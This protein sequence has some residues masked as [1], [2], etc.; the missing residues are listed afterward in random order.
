MDADEFGRLLDGSGP[1]RELTADERRA[2][3]MMIVES[4]PP[5]KHRRLARPIAIG[6]IAVTLLG[7]GGVAAAAVTG[8]W[9]QWAQD[10]PLAVLHYKL[11]SGIACEM[12]IGNI[13]E[14]PTEAA[15]VIRESLAG[16]E[17]NDD[18]VVENAIA[19][20]DVLRNDDAY[21]SAYNSTV[22]TYIED[23]LKARGLERA[24]PQYSAQANCE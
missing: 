16:V 1:V 11:P 10:D 24:V 7:G 2:V 4:A 23:A 18:D 9:D 6:A 15:D 17:F 19:G 21:Q 20:E 5:K 14:A 13:R 12:R 8:L 22:V 3:A